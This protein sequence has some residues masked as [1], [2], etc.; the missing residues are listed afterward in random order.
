MPFRPTSSPHPIPIAVPV[1]RVL[2]LLAGLALLSGCASPPPTPQDTGKLVFWEI[3]DAGGT[4]GHLLGSIHLGRDEAGFDPAIE[5]AL[6]GTGTLV[7]E[8]DPAELDPT[9]VGQLMLQ[10]GLLTDGRTLRDV[11]SEET[12]TLLEQ[13]LEAQGLSPAHVLYTEPWVALL[14]LLGRTFAEAGLD[15][16]QGVESR[17]LARAPPVAVV[18]LESAAFQLEL[19]DAL[20]LDQ[21]EELLRGLLESMREEEDPTLAR[22][23]RLLEA[24]RLGDLEAL[25]AL[26]MPGRGEDA[27]TDAL[28]DVLFT[29]RNRAM[30][31]RLDALLRGPGAPLFVTVGAL[32]TVGDEGL[33]ELL[34]ARG[35]SVRR[36]PRTAGPE[37]PGG[38]T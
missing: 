13:E 24:W 1:R 25:E 20:P 28:Y 3:R 37:A 17:V 23:D 11:L 16:A 36:V 35:W 33:P 26:G 18:G 38:G 34:R 7:L 32:H 9:L 29:Q 8:V 15:P 5:R 10:K 27:R 31:E 21:Q 6:A 14:T 19:F 12:W 30:A 2:A 4:R 22:L